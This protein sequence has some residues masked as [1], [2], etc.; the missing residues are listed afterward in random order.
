[1]TCTGMAVGQLGQT[2]D[3]FAPS[4]SLDTVLPVA[5]ADRLAAAARQH[6][7]RQQQRIGAVAN[8]GV[9]AG[10]RNERPR[11]R[12]K[13]AS[14]KL[15]LPEPFAPLI[16]LQRP[17]KFQLSRLDAAKVPNGRAACR[18][19]DCAKAAHHSRIGITT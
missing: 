6:A 18:L 8:Q 14:S 4:P 9:G 19:I 10:V 16:R 17:S 13:I 1:M 7:A 15:V 11:P 3:A 12:K 2:A 5:D